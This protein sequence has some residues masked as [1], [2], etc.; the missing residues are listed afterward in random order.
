MKQLFD[1]L[2][3]P[4][5][6]WFDFDNPLDQKLFEDIEYHNIHKRLL[7]KAKNNKKRLFIFIDEI[8]NLPEITKVIKF[9]ID[10]YKKPK[11]GAISGLLISTIGLVFFFNPVIAT[12]L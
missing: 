6:L 1:E 10:H 5:K 12:I 8:Q 2:D 9:L 7:K 3:E 4:N 11:M